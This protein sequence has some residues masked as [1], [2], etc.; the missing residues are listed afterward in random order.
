[1]KRRTFISLLGGAA[2]WP[3]A[4]RA[5]QG[6]RVWRIGVLTLYPHTDGGAQPRIAAFLATLQRWGWPDR[7]NV[8]IEYRWAGGDADREKVFAAELVRSTPDVIVVAG[9]TAL[10]ELKRLTSMIPI[11]FT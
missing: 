2:A 5:Q 6:E 7:R 11:V 10:A 1:M 3:L 4:A 9:W 8:R